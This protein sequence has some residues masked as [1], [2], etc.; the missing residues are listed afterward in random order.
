MPSTRRSMA[1]S[2]RSVSACKQAPQHVMRR[3]KG[4]A[5]AES[6][7]VLWSACSNTATWYCKLGERAQWLASCNQATATEE[8]SST[9]A[10][11]PQPY[12]LSWIQAWSDF[13]QQLCNAKQD[14]LHISCHWE[15]SE[16]SVASD[17]ENVAKPVLPGT[18]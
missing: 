1:K 8:E 9:G 4:S 12:Y 17:A 13:D 6:S 7:K 18:E 5:R 2:F 16:E 10:Q 15:T 14:N 3:M 11:K